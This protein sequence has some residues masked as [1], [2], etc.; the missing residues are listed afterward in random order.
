MKNFKQYFTLLF[1][2]ILAYSLLSGCRQ[3]M[4]PD[5]PTLHPCSVTIKVK[6]EPLDGVAVQLLA[7]DQSKWFANGFTNK[8]GVAKIQTQAEYSGAATGEYVVTVTKEVADPNWTP[9]PNKPEDGAPVISLIHYKYANKSTSP[10]RCTVKEG[11]NQ[12]EFD[13]ESP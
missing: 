3:P 8:S 5:M 12:F 4:P 13:V 1:I 7:V 11:Q 10:L 6:G 2:S 9:N